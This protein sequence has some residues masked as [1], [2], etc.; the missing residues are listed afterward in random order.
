MPTSQA[1]RGDAIVDKLDSERRAASGSSGIGASGPG[2][3]GHLSRPSAHPDSARASAS[4]AA[5]RSRS[6]GNKAGATGR[7]Q[8]PV[9]VACRRPLPRPSAESALEASL[10]Q[11]Q[12]P[13]FPTSS[14]YV[15]VRRGH[16]PKPSGHRRPRARIFARTVT[17]ADNQH[18]HTPK[19]GVPAPT[20][21]GRTAISPGHQQTVG[22]LSGTPRALKPP[23]PTNEAGPRS[24]TAWPRR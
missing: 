3:L 24:S 7:L 5:G 21:R 12:H 13:Y 23:G 22:L 6:A 11:L 17:T 10:P 4:P 15:P 19:P 20:P 16:A 9:L 1:A 14:L 2:R 8:T 18:I